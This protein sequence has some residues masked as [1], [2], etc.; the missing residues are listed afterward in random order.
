MPRCELSKEDL[1][2]FPH[3]LEWQGVC[4]E[5]A[6]GKHRKKLQKVLARMKKEI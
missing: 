3:K 5:Q 6:G 2:C 4:Q 1:I